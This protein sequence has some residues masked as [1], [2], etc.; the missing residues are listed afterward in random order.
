MSNIFVVPLRF[1]GSMR[2]SVNGCSMKTDQNLATTKAIPFSHLIVET[3]PF[4][5]P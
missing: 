1:D 5:D 2:G 3:G 4:P